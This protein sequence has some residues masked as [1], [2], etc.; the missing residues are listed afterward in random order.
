MLL[1]Y[2]AGEDSWESLGEQGDQTSQSQRK[3]TL[4]I[5]WKDWCWS[6]NSN[7]LATWCEELTLGKDPDT[8]KDLGQE[9]KGATE[10][11]MVWWDHQFN[12]RE[13]E[14]TQGGS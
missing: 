6:W 3:S 10:D 12:G 9:E 1:N 7:T 4:N 11:E 2:G 5:H 14:Q 13:F 8:G